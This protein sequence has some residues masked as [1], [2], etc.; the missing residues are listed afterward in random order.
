M[1]TLTTRSHV[2]IPDTNALVTTP[3]GIA[4]QTGL[5]LQG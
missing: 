2:R 3:K 1:L 5:H 4:Q